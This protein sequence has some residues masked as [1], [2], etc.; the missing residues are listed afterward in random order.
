MSYTQQAFDTIKI[1]LHN[2]HKKLFCALRGKGGFSKIFLACTHINGLHT[3]HVL[4][5]F[6]HKAFVRTKKPIAELE[7]EM[8]NGQKLQV[9]TPSRQME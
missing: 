2:I 8:L 9:C 6:F 3:V 4:Y 5:V 7:T 1:Y